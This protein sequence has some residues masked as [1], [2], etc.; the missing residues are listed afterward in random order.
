MVFPIVAYGDPVLR[1]VAVEIDKNYPELDKL[2][3]DMF[4]TMEKSKGVGLA[5]P[6]INKSIRLFVIDSTRMYDEDEKN[7]GIR[8]VFINARILEELG[9]EWAYEE[10]C[11]SIPNIREDV[12]RKAKLKIEYYDQKFKKHTK[13]FDGMTA[14]VIQHEYDHIEGKLFIDHLKPL[15]RSL[16]KGRLDKISKGIVDVEYKMRFPKK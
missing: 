7:E 2:I 14:R 12:N 15:K 11:L 8:E 6:Q 10:G 4:E 5:A 1:K 13:E 16:L 3:D 9:K